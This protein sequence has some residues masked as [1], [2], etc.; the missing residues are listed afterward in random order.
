MEVS[1]IDSVDFRKG[2]YLGQELTIRTHHTGVVRKRLV[3]VQCFDG[4]APH[5]MRYH[6]QPVL[7][8][9][10]DIFVQGKDKP[11]GRVGST[12]GNIGLALLRLEH[13]QNPLGL[14][15]GHLIKPFPSSFIKN[16]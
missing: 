9:G 2:C 10:Q 14:S 3:P 4:S 15:N 11:V 12:V 8:P 16:V 7:K 5:E 1:A 6:P 13:L